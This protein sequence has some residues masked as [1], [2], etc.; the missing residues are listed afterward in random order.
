MHINMKKF[1]KIASDKTHTTMRHMD[2]HEMKI[3]HSALSPKARKELADI[4]VHMADGGE[5]FTAE[6][7]PKGLPT[8]QDVQQAAAAPSQQMGAPIVINVGGQQPGAAAA[9]VPPP[10]PA[11]AAQPFTD[12]LMGFNP[13]G[14][15]PPP[16]PPPPSNQIQY[17]PVPKQEVPPRKPA[18]S[19]DAP[20]ATATSLA[21]AP[22]SDPYGTTEYYNNISKGL[23]EQK[24]GLAGE[25]AATGAQGRAEAA[26]LQKQ[27]ADQ[28]AILKGFQEHSAALEKERQSF[29]DDI[30]NQHI[31]PNRFINNMSTGQRITTA[32][33]L[34]LGGAGAGIAHQENP[35]LKMLQQQIQNDIEGQKEELGK[36]KTLLS[37]NMEHMKSVR[38]ATDMTRVM[39]SDTVST[40]L[41]AEAAKA[42]DPLAK[43]RALQAAGKIDHDNAQVLSQ[44][45]MRKALLGGMQGGSIS[46]ESVIRSIVPDGE[47]EHVYKE[48]SEAQ[49]LS[50]TRDNILSAFDRIAALN[51]AGN[52]TLSPIQSRKQIEALK[53]SVI[54]GLSKAT[55]GRYTEQDAGTIEKL[56]DT[57][58]ADPAAVATMRAQLTKLANE[59]A[60]FPRLKAWG[61]D[62]SSLGQY[63][64][65]GA[66]QIS[67]TPGVSGK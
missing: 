43:A 13:A 11:S 22:P 44:I 28:Q 60:N 25:A 37:A 39:M 9:P 55:A 65:T 23:A 61:I 52:R 38:D 50:K 17:P 57:A 59:K 8:P 34:I 64:P 46:P 26:T 54:P 1:K 49:E 5:T 66:S 35:V 3:A 12:P 32:I 4:P 62:A 33:G 10:A 2:G 16:A 21:A 58:Y 19:A 40:Q 67:F 6:Q 47:K 63:K 30:K 53:A 29:Q 51:T 48:L 14:A 45:A 20:Q 31:D 18:S 7:E 15:P 42:M 56:F 36:K 24:A 27:A 41:K